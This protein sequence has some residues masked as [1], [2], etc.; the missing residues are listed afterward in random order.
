MTMNE[1]DTEQVRA[2]ALAQLKQAQLMLAEGKLQLD[3]AE[4]KINE[5]QRLIDESADVL[6]RTWGEDA[7]APTPPSLVG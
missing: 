2:D 5:A 4:Q 3:E 7:P 1:Q 6:R